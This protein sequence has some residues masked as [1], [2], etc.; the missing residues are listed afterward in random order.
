MGERASFLR[1]V[2]AMRGDG[3]TLH[4]F[5]RDTV[6]GEASP[7]AENDLMDPDGVPRSLAQSVQRWLTR[8]T[9]RP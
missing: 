3:R 2:E 9:M 7:L 4:R 5:D 8:L 1:T 6:A